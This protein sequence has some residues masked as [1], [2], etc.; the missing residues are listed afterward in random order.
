MDGHSHTK[1]AQ[2]SPTAQRTG[3]TVQRISYHGWSDCY[4]ISNGQVEAV[5]VPAIGRVMQLRLAGEADGTFWEN[6]ALDGQLHDAESNDWINF[7]GDKCW[8]APQALWIEHQG[9][10][11]PPPVAF[12]ERQV[13]A[14]I[15]AQGVVVKSPVDPGFGIEVERR[16]ELNAVQPVLR[17]ATEYRKLTGGAV[18]VGIWTIT[19]MKEPERVCILLPRVSKFTAGYVR[20][21]SAEPA[22]LKIDGRLLSLGRHHR[23]QTKIGA[24]GSSLAWLGSSCVIRIDAETQ[25]GEYPDGGCVTEVYTNP[26][27]LPYVE[28]ETLGPLTTMNPGDKI[29]QTTVYTVAPRSTTD[30]ETEA[31]NALR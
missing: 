7:G 22:D 18:R 4:L 10:D 28:L 24:D 14:V 19:Q 8:P 23:H 30:L 26:D 20:L 31:R 12:G 15:S 25:P 2:V 29:E 27:P 17:I 5:V 3:V 13:K 6:R 1:V 11:W 21:M 16:I 9:R